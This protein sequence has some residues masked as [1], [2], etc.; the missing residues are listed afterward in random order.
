M[1]G[2]VPFAQWTRGDFELHFGGHIA[3]TQRR[4][5]EG[6]RYQRSATLGRGDEVLASFAGVVPL[7][8]DFGVDE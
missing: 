1:D 2:G 6:F 3:P 5:G 8:S 4:V 7:S